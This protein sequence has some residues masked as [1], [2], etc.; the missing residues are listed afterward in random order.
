[1]RVV[2]DGT[3]LLLP[4]GG[5]KSYVYYWLQHLRRNAAPE[6]T[7]DIFPRITN[8][9]ELNH[10]RSTQ[11]RAGTLWRLNV[12]RATNIA[13]SVVTRIAA[14]RAD[15]FHESNTHI[16]HPPTGAKLTATIH[17]MTCWVAPEL[18]AP[19]NVVFTKRFASKVYTRADRLIAVSEN[20]RRDAIDVL[21]F[22]AERIEVI[23]PGVAE[24]FFE[25]R[26]AR[27]RDRPYIL[28]NGVI[29]PRKN[30]DALIDAYVQCPA[31]VR[32]E[33]DLVLAGPFGWRA[34]DTRAR[35]EGGI[36]GVH[37]LRYAPEADLAALTAGASAVVYPSLYE[38][39]GLPVMQAMA[40]GV[41]VITSN[42]SSLPE[43][44]GG[45]A[46][47]VNPKQT[48]EIANALEQVLLSRS[49]AAELV[50]RG[51]ARAAGFR[52]TPCAQRSLA[53]FRAVVEDSA[54]R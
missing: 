49:V 47:L 4:G 7:I 10:L 41:P 45:A 2:I 12:V 50:S 29:E 46:L 53:F 31:T 13:G 16:L 11:T 15:V 54:V 36:R 5:V 44:A 8:L 26:H 25:S 43:V 42:V 18:H 19:E 33:F 40:A 23:Y 51:R 30:V 39:F 21:G 37:H 14:G 34:A 52:W 22:S 9:G 32:G 1:L 3:P 28:F 48:A 35:I 38:G 24:D 27:V 6:Q 20:S 17:D